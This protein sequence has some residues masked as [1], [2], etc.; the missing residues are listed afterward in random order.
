MFCIPLLGD[1]GTGNIE[2][3]HLLKEN[4]QLIL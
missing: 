4:M 3:A 2:M 1:R